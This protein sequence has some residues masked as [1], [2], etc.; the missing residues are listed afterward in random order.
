MLKKL[1][2]IIICLVLVL[3][4]VAINNTRVEAKA[5]KKA[6]KFLKGTWVSCGQSQSMKAIFTKKYVKFYN[7]S[8]K[9]G[10]DYKV[11]S[12]KKKGVYMGKDKIVSTKKKGKRWIIK[13]GKKGNYTYYKSYGKNVLECHWKEHG[14]WMY[15]GSSSYERYSRKV[16]K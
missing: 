6:M 9:K 13:V 5:T 12:P 7:L 8:Y 10:G 4:P 11:K 2:I 3:S 1:L 16:Y 15:S 14:E